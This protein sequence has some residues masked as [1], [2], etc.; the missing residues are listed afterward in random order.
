MNRPPHSPKNSREE[1]AERPHGTYSDGSGTCLTYR[2]RR[3]AP[4]TGAFLC[5]LVFF[6][7]ILLC[8]LVISQSRRTPAAAEDSD[9][10]SGSAETVLTGV[11][12]PPVTEPV[13]P[14]R[15]VSVPA[16]AVSEGDLILINPDHPYVF[17]ASQPQTVLYGNKSPVYV[18]STAAISLNTSLFPIFDGMLVDFSNA[19]GCK[20][21]L[22]TSGYRTYEF[23]AELYEARVKSQ[24]AEQAALYVAEAGYSEHHA[25]LAIDMVIYAN[26]KQY[27]SPDYEQ[28]A[29]LVEHAPD[30]GFI[31]RYTEEKQPITRCAPEPWHYRYVGTP[32]ARIITALGYCFEEYHEY[33]HAYTWEGE[34]LL[35]DAAGNLAATDGTSLP[36]SGYMIYYVPAA[37]EGDTE[38]PLPPDKEYEI[39]GDNDAGFI[40]TVKLG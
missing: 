31:L 15:T 33:L 16:S 8:I 40:V 36:A 28:A 5:A 14:C 32:H 38:I 6:L 20:D 3:P 17:P 13:I 22:V 21:V 27:Y 18:L 9:A 4:L 12:E 26:G 19:T 30:Y 39:S 11:T 1:Q 7:V 29:W 2:R 24:G 37:A 25:G 23:Q 10:L 34:R 35:A